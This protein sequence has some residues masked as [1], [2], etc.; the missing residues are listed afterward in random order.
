MKHVNMKY[1]KTNRDIGR[2]LQNFLGKTR[3]TFQGLKEQ[4]SI[5]ISFREAIKN[6]L[7]LKN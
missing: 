3:D 4:L 1:L 7:S 6:M 2:G 5:P